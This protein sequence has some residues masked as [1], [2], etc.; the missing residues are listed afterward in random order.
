MTALFQFKPL[1]LLYGTTAY[2]ASKLPPFFQKM[3]NFLPDMNFFQVNIFSLCRIGRDGL[4]S[5]DPRL[6]REYLD[7][8]FV[9]AVDFVICFFFF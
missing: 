4:V 7:V 1:L 6:R 3:C 9:E 8:S 2:C 5:T